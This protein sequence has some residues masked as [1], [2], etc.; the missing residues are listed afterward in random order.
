[1]THDDS[2]T[3][4]VS[5]AASLPED[6]ADS[7][8]TV[9]ANQFLDEDSAL[10]W[11]QHAELPPDLVEKLSKNSVATKSRKVKL[12]IVNHPK[13]PR[14][15]SLSLIRRLFTFD[16][17]QVAL[18]PAVAGDLKRAA[19]EVLINRLETISA[20]EKLSLAHR[21]SGRVAGELLL[22][23]EPRIIAAALENPRLTEA[24]VTNAL[25]HHEAS[26]AL[27]QTVCGHS[28]WSL[29]REIRIALLRNQH[30][31]AEH[32]VEF[33]KFLPNDVVR[34]ILQNSK[35]PEN[36]KTCLTQGVQP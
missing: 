26:F 29:R 19:E 3:T 31:P 23:A 32:A 30:T 7:D 17:M 6:L 5:P 13:A 27:V 14:Y 25:L 12:A 21:A 9:A 4:N 28:K 1:M 2:E 15:L 24:L 36:L 10:A 33:A 22:D 20:G 11:L 16:L 34:E 35:L 8:L 18:A